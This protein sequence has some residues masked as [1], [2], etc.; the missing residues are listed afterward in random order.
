MEAV[1]GSPDTVSQLP[2]SIY[3]NQRRISA[4]FSAS[5]LSRGKRLQHSE[6][7]D[8]YLG[9]AELFP[10]QRTQKKQLQ[11]F[12]GEKEIAEQQ[13]NEDD[14]GAR[15]EQS[16]SKQEEQQQHY[17]RPYALTTIPKL[18]EEGA[19]LDVTLHLGLSVASL[20]R[21]K[22][23]LRDLDRGMR[24]LVRSPSWEA[25]LYT[26][27]RANRWYK[28]PG[29]Q[30]SAVARKASAWRAPTV[31]IGYAEYEGQW[32][33]AGEYSAESSRGVWLRC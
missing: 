4:P 5:M 21:K 17:Q 14:S 28:L 24:T 6:S 3:Q 15:A 11:R 7:R 2:E 33:T 8:H 26:A 16:S 18:C 9:D 23:T 31:P 32:W 29:G 13:P 22:T 12:G 20:E 27:E 10:A 25:F 30:Q 1:G 19:G